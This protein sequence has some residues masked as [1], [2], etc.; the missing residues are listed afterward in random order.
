M[1]LSPLIRVSNLSVREK[2]KNKLLIKDISFDLFQNELLAIT[3]ESGAGKSVT[4]QTITK[5]LAENLE[6][7]SGEV[8]YKNQEILSLSPKSFQK[9]RGRFISIVFQSSIEYLNATLPCKTQMEDVILAHNPMSR[10]QAYVKAIKHLQELGIEDPERILR[11]YPH[12]ISGGQRQRLMLAMALSC[13]PEVLIL[14]EPTASIDKKNYLILLDIIKSLKDKR[15][16]GLIL[17]SHDLHFIRAIADRIM[18]LKEGKIEEEGIS[19]IV[20]NK[21]RRLYTQTLINKEHLKPEASMEVT[22][23]K[24]PLLAFKNVSKSYQSKNRWRSEPKHVVLTDLSFELHKKDRLGIIGKSGVGKSTLAKLIVQLES[25]TKGE[26]FFEGKNIQR[27]STEEI[28]ILRKKIQ[29]IFQDT[30]ASFDPLYKIKHAM[31]E[32]VNLVNPK[33]SFLQKKQLILDVLK[34]VNLGPK[35]LEALPQ[36]L[37]G[38][39]IQRACIARA[40]IV[41]PKLL[42]CDESINALDK[43]NQIDILKL[44][45]KLQSDLDISYIIISH[46]D[47]IIESFCNKVIELKNRLMLTID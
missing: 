31:M 24:L 27:A 33:A 41:K 43:L 34:Q 17:V 18:I 20:F 30:Y 38:G 39:E 6:V 13:D 5:I 2:H 4:L 25:P 15:N 44:L 12:E 21:P 26:I 35:I 46:D 29:L 8:Y 32:V 42:I 22:S 11:S 16:L 1:N 9:Y 19:N 36:N 7:T 45:E 47:T 10:K 23:E 37:S 28:I 3:G 14:D 40:L